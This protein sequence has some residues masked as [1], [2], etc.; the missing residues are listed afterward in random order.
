[1]FNSDHMSDVSRK[2]KV[3]DS[4]IKVMRALLSPDYITQNQ[5]CSERG[6]AHVF[7]SRQQL[8]DIVSHD[9][10]RMFCIVGPCS[11]HD[12]KAA[13]EY[14]KLL[15][16]LAHELKNE[17]LIVMR[18]YFE[19]PRTTIGWKG[20]MNDP[21]LDG[22]FRINEGIELARKILLGLTEL[23]LPVGVEWLDVITP[24]YICDLVTWGAIGART[25]ESQVHRQLV[26][27]LSM[28]VG[29]KNATSGD[30]QVCVDA[31]V[32]ARHPHCFLGVTHSGA[33]AIVETTGNHDVHVILRGGK[34]ANAENYFPKDV[35]G[36][37]AV[38]RKSKLRPSIVVDCSHGNS[39]K[40]HTRQHL[41]SES[42]AKQVAEGNQDIVGVMIESNLVAG[43]Q[44]LVSGHA[45]ELTYGQSITDACVDFAE[46]TKMLLSLAQAVRDR[47]SGLEY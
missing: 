37:A 8:A 30:V 31:C 15:A 3:I 47:R 38:M 2:D 34:G 18:V 28:P 26:S 6:V 33:A 17:L 14:G 44:N 39:R 36:V 29:F 46:T 45:H 40:D 9:D 1:M 27:G 16:E 43:K 7:S 42:V 11:I 5:P 23:G 19:K 32:S 4:R 13:L 21:H 12:A 22:S 35:Q 20:L 10:D 25:T 41:V 24:Q